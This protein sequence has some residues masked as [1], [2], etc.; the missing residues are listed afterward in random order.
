VKLF[1]SRFGYTFN[2][3]QIINRPFSVVSIL[4]ISLLTFACGTRSDKEVDISGVTLSEL[5]VKRL[6]QELF[7]ASSAEEIQAFLSENPV[8]AQRFFPF[9]GED[10]N[11]SVKVAQLYQL[12]T[13]PEVQKLYRE[14]Q[15]TFGDFSTIKNQFETAFKHIKYY[16]PEFVAPEINTIVTGFGNDMFVSDSLI[17]ISLDFFLTEQASYRPDM[18]A[19]VLRRYQP[20]YVVPT[21]ILLMSQ[22]YNQVNT[23]D[24]TMLADMVFYGKAY[25]FASHMLPATPDSLIIGYTSDQISDTDKNRDIVWEHFLDNKLLYET[26]HF[27]KV[28]YVDD[29][30]YTAEIGPKAPGAI[31]R[32]LGWEIVRKYRKENATVSL[33]ELMQNP[34]AQQIFTG[35]KYKGTSR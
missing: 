11:D 14:T 6:E 20:E 28:K 26:N 23:R 31:G 25:E 18:P 27:T 30:P 12:I 16:Y 35:S 5:Q 34:D 32:W 24:K 2:M 9:T 8:V 22:K 21:A 10:V 1:R 3:K 4:F 19:Y 29:R 17:V 13:N 33:P 15:Q 7:A